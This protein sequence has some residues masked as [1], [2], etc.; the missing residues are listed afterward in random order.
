MRKQ[1]NISISYIA[2]YF[3]S[4]QLFNRTKILLMSFV[5]FVTF[6]YWY[7]LNFDLNKTKQLLNRRYQIKKIT[8]VSKFKNM[9]FSAE[10]TISTKH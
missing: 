3:I 10:N 6:Y 2:K 7:F 8:F 4:K 1:S 9:I 5:I